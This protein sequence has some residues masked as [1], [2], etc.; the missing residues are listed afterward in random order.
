M[1]LQ[2][3]LTANIKLHFLS[4]VELSMS[5]RLVQKTMYIS[6]ETRAVNWDSRVQ[7]G[8]TSSSSLLRTRETCQSTV[9][10]LA[11]PRVPASPQEA[12]PRVQ[13][14]GLLPALIET[15]GKVIV[16]NS[17]VFIYYML[18]INWSIFSQRKKFVSSN[19]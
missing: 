11:S 7:A 15:E 1:L 19:R 2:S 8:L 9:F 5:L 16:T 13:K 14:I 4:D 3:G 6:I 10:G 12:G 18:Y 17:L